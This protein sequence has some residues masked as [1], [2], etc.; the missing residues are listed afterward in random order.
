MEK[1]LQDHSLG[2]VWLIQDGD[3][4]IGYVV[5]TPGYSLEYHGRDAFVDEICIRQSH[6]GKGIG[7]QIIQFVEEA[8]RDLDVR[9]LHLEVER[10]NTKAQAFYH[11]V[12]FEDHDRYLLT[13]KMMK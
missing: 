3:E 11:K 2:R 13:K 10:A 12:G 9:T 8:C 4:A 6:R 5:L 1:I 7:K